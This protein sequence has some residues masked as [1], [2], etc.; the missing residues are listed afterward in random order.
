MSSNHP[1]EPTRFGIPYGKLE[2]FLSTR[3]LHLKELVEP[4]QME[5]RYLTLGDGSTVGHVPALFNLVVAQA[6]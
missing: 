6:G 4:E 5:T 2:L 1:G 3:G